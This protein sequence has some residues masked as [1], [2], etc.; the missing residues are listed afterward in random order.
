MTSPKNAKPKAYS[1]IRFSTPEQAGG[2]SLR[3]QTDAARR[4]AARNGLELDESLSFQDLGV[5]AHHGRNAEVGALGAFLAAVREER[6]PAGSYLLVES[7]DRISRQTVRKAVR[8]LESIAEAGITVV[9]LS[10][11]GRAYSEETLDSDPFAFVMMSLRFIRAH[12][13]S[14]TKGMRVAAAYDRKRALAASKQK[15]SAPFTRRLPAWLRWD[16]ASLK[17]ELIPDRAKIIGEVFKK[18]D[19]GWGQY[20]I[21][22]WLIARKVPTWGNGQRWHRS[23]IRKLLVNRA[24]I[25]TFTPHRVEKSTGMRK[26]KPLD[27]IPN[28]WPAA[29]DRRLFERVSG[30]TASGAPRGRHA[31]YPSASIFAG[32]LRCSHCGGP[33]I[34]VS[35]GDHAYIVCS[36]AHA[37]GQC[38]YQ[39]VK[40]GDV[41]RALISNLRGICAAAPRGGKTKQLEK[42][43]DNLDHALYELRQEAEDLVGEL[44]RSKS[45]AIRRR[46]R[47]AEA[48]IEQS[49]TRSRALRNEIEQ[50]GEPYVAKRIA[51]LRDELAANPIDVPKANRAMREAFERI[52]ANPEHATLSIF[53]RHSPSSPHMISFPSRHYIEFSTVKQKARSR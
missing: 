33:A 20:R 21:A 51:N 7:L 1:Y 32:V 44:A 48:Q 40:F 39:A 41:E 28:F 49:D 26:R 10:D 9:D 45:D 27:P 24:V 50:L 23:Y 4:Y 43:A 6:V 18:A 37:V 16:E 13:E 30:R 46:L 3:R 22:R 42:E 29:V 47:E 12:E 31:S 36:K 2:D 25:G 53:W 34:R 19:S 5:S 52:V 14:A 38:K 15:A 35:K 8:T 11:G 17:Y